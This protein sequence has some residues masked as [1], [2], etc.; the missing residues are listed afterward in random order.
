MR[1]FFKQSI[2]IDISKS[3]FTACIYTKDDL[4]ITC[5]SEVESFPN[6]KTG[7]N[8]FL[9]WV[10]KYASLEYETLFIMEATGV[11]YESLAYHL[12]KLG[13]NISVVLPVKVKYYSKSLNIKSKNDEIDARVIARM[14]VD[15]QFDLWNPPTPILKELRELSR[16]Y[17]EL[18]KEATYCLNHLE[19]LE[20]SEN[21]S[22]YIVKSYRKLHKEIVYQIN[23][24]E[25]AIR[26]LI[27]KDKS[28]ASKIEK[29]QSIKGVGFITVIIIVAET[30]GFSMIS[31]RKQLASYAG[32]DIVERQSGSSIRGKTKISKKGN[33]RIRA[34]LYFPA[35]ACVKFNST[36]KEDYHRIIQGKECK[37]IGI[38]AI[39]RKILLLLYALW[40]TDSVFTE[41]V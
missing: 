33:R 37:K 38:I 15:Q 10:R 13:K 35:M 23:K 27:S 3:S 36:L 30:Q 12:H 20:N 34:A 32:F 2:G 41:P 17:Q 26:K 18:K 4:V 11:Y 40:K 5:R 24:C 14:G 8:Q 9:K 22:S 29:L 21:P 6:T 1:K 16:F 28:L 19:A 7:F 25:E 31:N 39:Q